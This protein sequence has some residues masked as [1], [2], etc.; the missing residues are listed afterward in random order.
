MNIIN[1][2]KIATHDEDELQV[3]LATLGFGENHG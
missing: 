3:K 1:Y 2:D